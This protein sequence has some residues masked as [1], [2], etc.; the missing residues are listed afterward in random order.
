MTDNAVPRFH[1]FAENVVGFSGY[2]GRG[3]A[4]GTAFGKVIAQHVLG[5][6]TEA[7]LPLPLTEPKSAALQGSE[8]S[9]L[10][11][12]CTDSPFRRRAFLIRLTVRQKHWARYL[13]TT[14]AVSCV[15]AIPIAVTGFQSAQVGLKRHSRDA[16]AHLTHSCDEQRTEVGKGPASGILSSFDISLKI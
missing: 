6:I 10:R 9:L 5:E 7:E 1:K 11:S 8:G 16:D 3:I 15:L 13:I 12:R 4:P 14:F 2:N